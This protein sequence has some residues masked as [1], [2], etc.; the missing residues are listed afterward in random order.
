MCWGGW[1]VGAEYPWR[2]SKGATLGGYGSV[3]G[4]DNLLYAGSS[5]PGRATIINLSLVMWRSNGVYSLGEMN[6]KKSN[7][8]SHNSIT[9]LCFILRAGCG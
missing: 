6:Q 2:R 3:P 5:R 1:G 8:S 4:S 7:W 9:I